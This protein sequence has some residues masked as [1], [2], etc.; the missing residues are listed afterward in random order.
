MQD[1]RQSSADI[2]SSATPSQRGRPISP[3][4][5]K[6]RLSYRA[7]IAQSERGRPGSPVATWYHYL[8]RSAAKALIRDWHTNKY[9]LF[10]AVLV[11]LT[12]LAVVVYY[13]N[14]PQPEIY[15]DTETYLRVVRQFQGQGQLADSQRVPGFPLLILLVFALAGQGNLMA[16][17]FA[18]AMLFIL[19]TFET[20]VLAAFMLR[21]GWAALL[22][23]LL[24]G[25]NVTLLP[26]IKSI[27]SEALALWLLV[28]LAL[29]A[30]LFVYTLRPRYLWLM[31]GFSLA[32]FLTRAEW[33]Y[34]SVPLFAYLLLVAALRVAARRL[35]LHML[36]SVLLL[37]AL[38]GGYLVQT[39]FAGVADTQNINIWGKLLQY[40][41]QDEAPPEYAQVKQTVDTYLARGIN[42]PRY[43]LDHEPSL[44]R[45]HYALAGEYAK[46][47]ILRHPV[48]FLLKSVPLAFWSLTYWPYGTQG[49][50]TGRLGMP[51]LWLQSV[52]RS[53]YGW[54]QFFPVCAALWI[55]LLCW[56]RTARLWSV[57]AMGVVVL[58][59]LY[60]LIVTTLAGYQELTRY[61]VPFSPLL[62]LIVWGSL[63]IGLLL[64]AQHGPGIIARAV[65]QSFLRNI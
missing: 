63:L 62:T 41:M 40:K 65:S 54:N 5:Q 20:Y 38:L 1:R 59:T 7:T 61:H 48:E 25:V 16:V 14:H 36:V 8:T 29:A 55:F 30:V 27:L 26:F 51:L 3:T 28:S 15:P 50:P 56:R 17:S 23:G 44:S 45:N 6:P 32:L 22:I 58:L 21:R 24:V 4:G 64:V 47:I 53:L 42:D 33:V 31:T 46:A 43:I 49:L 2:T 52:F 18:H 9:A 10:A 57:Q 13:V 35:L 19:A 12:T 11:L 34:V 37:Y 39:H 60:G